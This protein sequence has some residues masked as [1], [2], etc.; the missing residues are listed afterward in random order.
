MKQPGDDFSQQEDPEQ[1]TGPD[2]LMDV[3]PE[4]FTPPGLDAAELLNMLQ[5]LMPLGA[6]KLDYRSNT[7]WF[8]SG[9]C[10]LLGIDAALPP[11]AS[12]DEG[13]AILLRGLSETDRATVQHEIEMCFSKGTPLQ[14]DLPFQ[15]D[16]GKNI[17]LKLHVQAVTDADRHLKSLCGYVADITHQM[18]GHNDLHLAKQRLERLLNN[19][20]GMAYSC[21]LNQDWTTF[22][23]SKGFT[24]L[25]GHSVE[26]IRSSRNFSFHDMILPEDRQTIWNAMDAAASEGKS[27]RV[28]YRIRDAQGTVKHILDQGTLVKDNGDSHLEGFLMDVSDRHALE[29]MLRET[30]QKEL[31]LERARRTES[32]ARLAG[33][34]AHHF[35]N[36]MQ[37][38]IG[39]LEIATHE[40]NRLC[41]RCSIQ[42]ELENAHK[43]AM[44][45]ARIS[46]QMLS[47][48]GLTV[49]PTHRMDLTELLQKSLPGLENSLP[50]FTP[51]EKTLPA[52]P[53]WV[54]ANENELRDVL[55]QLLAN[56]AEAAPGKTVTLQLETKATTPHP[57]V[58]APA[59]CLR[60]TDQGPGIP[61]EMLDSIFE[62]FFTTKFTGRGLGLSIAMGI[63]HKFGG[64]LDMEPQ[65]TGC[66]FRVW[67]PVCADP[68]PDP[69]PATGEPQCPPLQND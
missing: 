32:L 55:W 4:R 65:P 40:I 30:A 9:L 63:L 59:A 31:Q 38:V 37:G 34:V 43:V 1:L 27:Y 29:V 3:P 67:L 45:S 8:S 41:P 57:H 53:M 15:Q 52:T 39:F 2:L 14:R 54:D 36:K 13:L 33:S 62:P 20:P 18:H 21:A 23:S 28:S 69:P 42:S 7:T 61:K 25:T 46:R 51:I 64:E 49:A 47:Y 10:R 58:A 26:D 17:W 5:S 19:L 35:N 22:F 48:L 56:A 68:V 60:I 44:E 16:S 24:E 50:E 11:P 66:T 12:C 6:W